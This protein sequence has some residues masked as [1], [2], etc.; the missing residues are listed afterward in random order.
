MTTYITN[1][2]KYSGIQI[3]NLAKLIIREG[4]TLYIHK[5]NFLGKLLLINLPLPILVLVTRKFDFIP[6][7]FVFYSYSAIK[8]L[9]YKIKIQ[10]KYTFL[11]DDN[12][13]LL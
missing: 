3:S 1:F 6:D 5:T 2:I 13:D 7:Y 10:N 8:T 11:S 12:C 9:D 4:I